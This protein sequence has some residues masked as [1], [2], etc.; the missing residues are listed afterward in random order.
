MPCAGA[1]TVAGVLLGTLAPASVLTRGGGDWTGAT[2]VAG[3]AAVT[4]LTVL[5]GVTGVTDMGAA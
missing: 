2:G 5:T 4:V 3:V 1:A